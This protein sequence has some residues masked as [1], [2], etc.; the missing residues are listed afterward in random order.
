MSLVPI[1]QPPIMRALTTKKERVI[2]MRAGRDARLQ[3]DQAPLSPSSSPSS[4]G[5]IAP[6]GLPLLGTIMLGNLMRE[7]GVVTRL[8]EGLRKRD[9]Q[10]RDPVPRPLHRRHD[11]GP[12]PFSSPQTLIILG[13]GL[14]RHLPRYRLRRPV[15]QAHVRPDRRQG[16]S[17]HRRGGHFRLPDG[18]ARR[19]E[20][21]AASTT[22][23]TTCSCTPM[24]ANAGGQI[25]S[26]IAA[27]VMLSVL[28]GMGFGG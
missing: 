10:H 13:L 7:C 28:R 1:I 25:G 3:D 27:A 14:R 12:T 22:R 20:R 15:R 26:V 11:G 4:R 18:G 17:P 21:G 6:K 8:T 5:L 9:R 2:V 19:P 23:R 24:G 16:Q